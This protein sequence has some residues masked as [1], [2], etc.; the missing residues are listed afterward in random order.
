MIAIIP[1]PSGY[2]TR[3]VLR[4]ERRGTKRG[5]NYTN[6]AG[7][8]DLADEKRNFSW[9]VTLYKHHGRESTK[10]LSQRVMSGRVG[11]I[12]QIHGEII[13][14]IFSIIFSTGNA[15]MRREDHGRVITY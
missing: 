2:L 12:R 5:P 8:T 1:R 9:H 11:E 10:D 14:R 13:L 6:A 4:E 7:L 15:A 3:L